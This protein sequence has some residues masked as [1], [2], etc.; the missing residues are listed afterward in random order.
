MLSCNRYH[1]NVCVLRDLL[2][3]LCIT[4]CILTSKM[5]TVYVFLSQFWPHISPLYKP[6]AK[7]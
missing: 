5:G 2:T 6:I 1:S 3:S 4:F 7:T